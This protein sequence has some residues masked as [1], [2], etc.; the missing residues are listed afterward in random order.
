MGAGDV[1]GMEPDITGIGGLEGEPVILIVVFAHQ[2][3]GAVRGGKLERLG[4]LL[5]GMFFRLFSEDAAGNQLCLDIVDFG[6]AG[7]GLQGGLDGG[8][9]PDVLQ[10]VLQLLLQK[11]LAAFQLIVFLV[12]CLHVF[13][14]GEP[15]VHLYGDGFPCLAVD[16]GNSDL[17]IHP[18]LELVLVG[19]E[20]V[21]L[22]AVF[23]GIVSGSYVVT[24]LLY[25]VFSPVQLVFHQ[26]PEPVLVR[27]LV[28]ACEAG[29]P[30]QHF[31]DGREGQDGFIGKIM[32]WEGGSGQ[33]LIVLVDDD[34]GS[35]AWLPEAV[36]DFTEGVFQ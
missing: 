20:I 25:L 34:G 15:L 1:L 22:D 3:L 31:A 26:L 29:C 4:L 21:R 9:V 11:L 28:A 36:R 10:A 19:H 17:R 23:L 6:Q 2:Y 14:H 35:A 27:Y 18:V 30:A 13:H 5:R 16:V 33:G 24:Q 32:E 7:G 8:H 12:V